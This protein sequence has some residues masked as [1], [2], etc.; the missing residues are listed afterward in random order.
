MP[1][2][3]TVALPERRTDYR[4]SS[5]TLYTGFNVGHGNG[6]TATELWGITLH[7]GVN[8]CNSEQPYTQDSTWGYRL[9]KQKRQSQGEANCQRGATVNINHEVMKC[10]L[11]TPS[12]RK[13]K[14]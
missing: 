5:H 13:H 4:L 6:E 9:N 11:L 10:T 2:N 12:S 7:P 3:Y 8:V 14:Q 1:S